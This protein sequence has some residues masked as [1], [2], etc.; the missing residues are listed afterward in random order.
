MLSVLPK[1]SVMTNVTE[2]AFWIMKLVNDTTA[3]RIDVKRGIETDSLTANSFTQI[4]FIRQDNFIRIFGLPDTAKV[5][6]VK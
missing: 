2:D 6:I 3:V 4:K 5:E 1:S